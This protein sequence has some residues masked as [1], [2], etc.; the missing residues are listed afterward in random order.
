MS[1]TFECARLSA[2][3]DLKLTHRTAKKSSSNSS[4]KKRVFKYFSFFSLTIKMLMWSWTMTA[5]CTQCT[6]RWVVEA[7]SAF[8]WEKMFDLLQT[9]LAS[10][11]ESVLNPPK[12]SE[13][14][15]LSFWTRE[16]LNKHQAMAFRAKQRKKT[17]YKKT[18]SQM[19]QER[20]KTKREHRFIVWA[21]GSELEMEMTCDGVALAL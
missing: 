9:T 7:V 3:L 18:E 6:T 16:N 21:L 5:R 19:L 12:S 13:G 17:K 1:D 8:A 14:S 20:R 11:R 2:D 4:A 15:R 10:D